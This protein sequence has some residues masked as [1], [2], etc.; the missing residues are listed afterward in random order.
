[1]ERYRVNAALLPVDSAL[2]TVLRER[3]DWKAVYQDH[4]AVLFERTENAR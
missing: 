1:L 3:G 2:A 4:V